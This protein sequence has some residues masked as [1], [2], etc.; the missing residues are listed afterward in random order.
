MIV[1]RSINIS[2]LFYLMSAKRCAM[3]RLTTNKLLIVEAPNHNE[4]K[5]MFIPT[6]TNQILSAR[7]SVEHLIAPVAKK[8]QILNINKYYS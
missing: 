4:N 5:E 7:L 2:H 8:E 1:S 3:Q 6:I